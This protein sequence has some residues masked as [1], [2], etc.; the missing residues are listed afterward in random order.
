MRKTVKHELEIRNQNKDSVA[1]QP[2]KPEPQSPAK[3]KPANHILEKTSGAATKS[4]D[5]KSVDRQVVN[6]AAVNSR[7]P[8][9][10]VVL[11]DKA[12]RNKIL[13]HNSSSS[14]NF[15]LQPVPLRL[16]HNSQ[17]ASQQQRPQHLPVTVPP[18]YLQQQLSKSF[19]QEQK[20]SVAGPPTLPPPL[21]VSGRP[22]VIQHTAAHL[23]PPTAFGPPGVFGDRKRPFPFGEVSS[24]LVN[25]VRQPFP[26]PPPAHSNP[27]RSSVYGDPRHL[28]HSVDIKRM[29]M[30]DARHR[31]TA[32]ADEKK[33]VINLECNERL[34]P[35]DFSLR[36]ENIKTTVKSDDEPLCLVTHTRKDKERSG[37]RRK[38][39]QPHAPWQTTHK[40][41]AAS[42]STHSH[43][44]RQALKSSVN[45]PA[46]K[47]D[48]ANSRMEHS[49]SH[50]HSRHLGSHPAHPSTVLGPNKLTSAAGYMFSP[51]QSISSG[52][53]PHGPVPHS[54]A[55]S[56]SNSSSASRSN[57]SSNSGNSSS[58]RQQQ[59][60]TV[61]HP[62]PR[63]TAAVPTNRP[64]PMVRVT[65]DS[66]CFKDAKFKQN[67]S[68]N[69]SMVQNSTRTETSRNGYFD[70]WVDFKHSFA[71]FSW[72]H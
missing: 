66:N 2:V 22:S 21:G 51:P 36:G 4:V 68:R 70:L 69:Q 63:P 17:I 57:S 29:R 34:E 5:T 72:T 31:G 37:E 6:G 20:P 62:T 35:M 25:D 45:H 71:C 15:P 30:E 64:D 16:P 49:H 55:G 54:S 14:R 47:H 46:S 1:N 44:S 28:T 9:P 39:Q 38:S 53:P 43:G 59:Q 60:P 41:G 8:P 23:G 12:Q 33:A 50:S 40:S 3:T 26:T 48:T 61:Q 18:H 56:G 58:Q 13:G 10:G 65:Q 27:Q 52:L 42:T 32:P 7:V 19:Q 11:P 67:G 24:S